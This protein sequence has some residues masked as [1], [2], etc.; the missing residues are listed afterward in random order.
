MLGPSRPMPALLTST[1]TRPKSA[2]H[3]TATAS[4]TRSSSATSS[5]VGADVGAAAGEP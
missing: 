4:M 5:L 1:S 3:A 2:D